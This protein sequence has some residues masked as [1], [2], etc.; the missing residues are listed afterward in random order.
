MTVTPGAK[1][2]DPDYYVA[3]VLNELLSGGMF[4]RLFIEIRENRG[5]VYSAYSRH[6]GNSELG[7][8]QCYAGTTPENA[9]E[10]IDV[11]STELQRLRGSVQHD[12][13]KRAKVNLKAALVIGE[14]S[15]SARACSNA[16]DWMLC[17]AVRPIPTILAALDRVEARDIDRYLERFPFDQQTVLTLGSSGVKI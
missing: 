5:L 13:L 15:S 3:K 9:Q 1:F 8:F 10:T 14:E 12:E 16:S 6:I 11:L 17:G 4:G 2:G 7:V